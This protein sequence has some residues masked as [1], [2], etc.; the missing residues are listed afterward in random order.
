RRFAELGEDLIALFQPEGHGGNE[1]AACQVCG[2]EHLGT[3]EEEGVRKCPPCRSYEDLGDDLRRALY[4]W[5]AEI[6]P[7][8]PNPPM[9]KTPGGWQGV[10]AA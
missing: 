8:V 5:M 2:R 4:L 7:G 3:K 9:A 6:Q 10:L 1:E